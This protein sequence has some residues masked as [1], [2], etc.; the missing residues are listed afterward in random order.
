MIKGGY[1]VEVDYKYRKKVMWKF[2]DD[3]VVEG[4]FN[5]RSKVYNVLMLIY[6]TK[7]E[8]DVLGMM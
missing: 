7:R 6:S 8:K 2:I 4:G 1:L 5:T 3:H